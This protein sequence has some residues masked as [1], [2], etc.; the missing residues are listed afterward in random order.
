[1]KQP[2]FAS[3]TGAV[4]LTGN[5]ARLIG[6]LLFQPVNMPDDATNDEQQGDDEQSVDDCK[7]Y[8][9]KHCKYQYTCRNKHDSPVILEKLHK[10]LLNPGQRYKI[11]RN[12]K[13]IIHN[14][15]VPLHPHFAKITF[16]NN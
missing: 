10:N 7:V 11:I 5:I 3:Q 15:L 8:S 4:C 9:V 16:I 2:L 12:S 1:M 14:Y 13:F 6:A